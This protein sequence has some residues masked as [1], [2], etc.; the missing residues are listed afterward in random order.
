MTR[1]DLDRS[2]GAWLSTLRFSRVATIEEVARKAEIDVE[3][4]A[5]IE[6]G[7]ASGTLTEFLACAGALNAHVLDFML[8]ALA[9]LS[10][11]RADE[12]DT[13]AWGLDFNRLAVKVHDQRGRFLLMA[14]AI[15][16]TPHLGHPLARRH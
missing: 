14:C 15:A 16:L 4:L 12:R 10:D 1:T 7:S 13:A 8:P 5:S 6:D 9:E 2:V 3:R 11:P